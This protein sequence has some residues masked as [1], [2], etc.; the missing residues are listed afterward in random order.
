MA[1]P[2]DNLRIR[3]EDVNER[4]VLDGLGLVRGF[5]A[6]D[7]SARPGGYNS[8]VGKGAVRPDNAG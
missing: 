8:L 5:L 4:L 6:G 7:P 3:R 1:A 2:C